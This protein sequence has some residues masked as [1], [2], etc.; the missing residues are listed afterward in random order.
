VAR[1]NTSFQS[2]FTRS[3]LRRE[4]RVSS[5]ATGRR[6]SFRPLLDGASAL[7]RRAAPSPGSELAPKP[8]SDARRGPGWFDSS[9]DLRSGLEVHE[10]LP[11]DAR[12]NE[13]LEASLRA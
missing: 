13:W 8:A 6:A 9:W 12:L 4:G 3:A 2:F 1:F 5:A 11:A 7:S 10:G